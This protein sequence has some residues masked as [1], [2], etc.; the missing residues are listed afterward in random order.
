M[1]FLFHLL[2]YFGYVQQ[3]NAPLHEAFLE[4]LIRSCK[5]SYMSGEGYNKLLKQTTPQYFLSDEF[6]LHCQSNEL[7]T[8]LS[9]L[10]RLGELVSE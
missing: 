2:K 9:I 6:S 5:N 8:V 1:S 3:K 10:R 7:Y 4:T